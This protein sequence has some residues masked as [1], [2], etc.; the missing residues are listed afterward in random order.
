MS[1]TTRRRSAT[2]TRRTAWGGSAGPGNLGL[3][4]VCSPTLA[5]CSNTLRGK[6][7]P[8]ARPVRRS[9]CQ[10]LGCQRREAR[11]VAMRELLSRTGWH[12]RPSQVRQASIETDRHSGLAAPKALARTLAAPPR[13]RGH[14][15]N[16]AS[17]FHRRDSSLIGGAFGL[18]VD[19]CEHAVRRLR[20]RAGASWLIDSF[21]EALV[22]DDTLSQRQRRTSM[23]AAAAVGD[24]PF[25][26]RPGTVGSS[27]TWSTWRP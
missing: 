8:S 2:T 13:R 27:S 4:V 7:T 18:R 16:R 26:G 15:R 5:A 10:Q 25:D 21:A 1:G 6:T 24:S 3:R 12:V 22:F 19:V 23:A 11:A 9:P 14:L 20:R 17:A